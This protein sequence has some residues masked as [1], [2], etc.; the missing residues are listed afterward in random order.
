LNGFCCAALN[1][2]SFLNA[3]DRFM[4]TIVKGYT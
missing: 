4:S 3:R 1:D 2:Q